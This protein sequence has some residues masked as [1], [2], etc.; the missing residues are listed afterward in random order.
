MRSG[1]A[2]KKHPFQQILMISLMRKFL[3]FPV[4]T[5]YAIPDTRYAMGPVESSE[6]MTHSQVVQSRNLKLDRL[7]PSAASRR[8]IRVFFF[9]GY[10]N[11]DVL[12]TYSHIHMLLFRVYMT[13]GPNQPRAQQLRR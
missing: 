2:L 4:L 6:L 10:D 1:N 9:L 7:R 3:T 5:R 11:T 8:G 12:Q 13:R